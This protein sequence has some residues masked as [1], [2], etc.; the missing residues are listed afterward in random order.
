M[1]MRRCEAGRFRPKATKLT[2]AAGGFALAITMSL[3]TAATTAA[4][5]AIPTYDHVVLAIFENHEQSNVIAAPDAPYL[6]S[7]AG[8][9]ASFTRSFAIEHPSQPNYLDLFSG[10][11]QGVRSDACPHTFDADNVGHQ[12]IAAGKT[13]AGYSEDLPAAGS[14][15]CRTPKYA[16]KHNPWSN[17]GD[18]DQKAVDLPYGSFPSDFT[19]LPTYSWVVPNLCHDMHDCA[20]VHR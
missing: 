8:Q 14:S 18:L 15:T 17:F 9:G 5:S 13:F 20:G 11:N 10:S 12:L 7:L 19:D 4:A 6:T 2:A 1:G 3:F 16:R